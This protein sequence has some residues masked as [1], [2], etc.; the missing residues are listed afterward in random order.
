[1]LP[2]F[3]VDDEK[4]WRSLS[5]GDMDNP[6]VVIKALQTLK[7]LPMILSDILA[8]AAPHQSFPH[9]EADQD[10]VLARADCLDF[11]TIGSHRHQLAPVLC[12]NDE[13]MMKLASKCPKLLHQASDRLLSSP[14]FVENAVDSIF[15]NLQVCEAWTEITD[16]LF[17]TVAKVV[18][19]NK[20]PPSWYVWN[21]LEFA[22]RCMFFGILHEAMIANDID[23][24][25]FITAKFQFASPPYPEEW[26]NNH[27]IMVNLIMSRSTTFLTCASDQQLVD[28]TFFNEA[29][30]PAF[31]KNADETWASLSHAQKYQA[32]FVLAA[33]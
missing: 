11:P 25:T 7:D 4:T 29:I 3:D 31:N 10:V 9:L 20:Y 33:L 28:P 5:N 13:V 15:A 32:S 16:G 23:I 1:M 18:A 2:D 14:D 12:D 26:R 21:K 17:P 27:D 19:L 8:S 30:Q 24:I 22:M 6:L